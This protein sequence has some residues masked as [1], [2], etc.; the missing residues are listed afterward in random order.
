MRLIALST[1]LTFLLVGCGD[2]AMSSEGSGGTAGAGGT[3]GSGGSGEFVASLTHTYE[4]QL[5]EVAEETTNVCQSWVLDNDEPIYVRK[6]RQS[7]EGGW[8]HSN[9]FFVPETAYPPDADKEG[10]G[11]TLGGTWKCTD[12][13]FREYLA[14][15]AGGVFF[16]QSTQALEELQAFPEGAALEIPPR[17]MIVG[18]T[19]LL[20]ISAAPM[21]TA[22][23]ME[24]ETAPRE[25]VS[26]RLTPFSFA[27]GD[28]RIPPMVDGVPTES[29][30]SMQC[31]LREPFKTYL[32]R[33]VVD[34]NV[35]YVLG[36][37]HQ[38]GNYFNLSFVHD[39]GTRETVFEIKN[40]IGEPIGTIIDPPMNNNGA[41]QLRSECG[42]INNTD[43]TLRRGLQYGEMCDFLAYTDANLKIGATGRNNTEMGVNEDGLPLFE[44]DCN[45]ITGFKAYNDEF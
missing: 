38:W 21:E 2:D 32:D 20:N 22:M 23:T 17:S 18:S 39:D 8:H 30:T 33:D 16:A 44:T 43:E 35:Y 19:H 6:I 29:R 15:A 27:I 41:G 40:R 9:W 12:R 7:N 26:V 45:D 14:A 1:I 28:L 25:D 42:F 10:P 11:A 5:L 31:D 24:V 13:G 36:H 37:Y 4:P 3:A 34:Y